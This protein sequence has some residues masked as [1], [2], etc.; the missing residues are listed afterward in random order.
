MR[1][2]WTVCSNCGAE[3]EKAAGG[4]PHS[5]CKYVQK[6]RTPKRSL[7]PE[8]KMPSSRLGSGCSPRPPRSPEA[9]DFRG[10]V[11]NRIEA[12]ASFASML[13][14]YRQMQGNRGGHM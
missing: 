9:R 1:S 4:L 8:K 2:A 7:R 13:L 6:Q 11:Q 3:N 12:Q 14:H 10:T 5:K